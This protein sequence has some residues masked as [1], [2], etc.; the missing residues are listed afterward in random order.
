MMILKSSKEQKE[1]KAFIDYALSEEGQKLVAEAWLMPARTDI[2]AKRPL[3]KTLKLLPE[4]AQP[5]ASRKEV[6]DRFASLF[7]QR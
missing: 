2:D 4:T 7:N 3:F 1:A 6:L 5:S